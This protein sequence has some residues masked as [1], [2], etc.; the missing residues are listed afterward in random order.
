MFVSIANS[1][2]I[3]QKPKMELYYETLCPY[4]NEFVVNQL[5]PT[6]KKLVNY[7]NFEVIPFGNVKVTIG[8]DGIPLFK[9]QH[10]AAEC[11]GNRVQACAIDINQNL[12]LSLDYIYCMYNDP[13]WKNTYDTWKR[14]ATKLSMDWK[15]VEICNEGK[16]GFELIKINWKRTTNLIPPKE[17]VPWIV[18]DGKHTE[19]MQKEAQADLLSYLCKNQLAGQLIPQCQ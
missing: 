8:P 5:V 1:V 10:G 7:V 9:C 11:F 17:Y 13:D 6:Y 19:T 14:C 15:T 2:L 3:V 16:R 12:T 18:I 4:C